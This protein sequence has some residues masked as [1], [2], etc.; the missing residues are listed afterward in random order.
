M[1]LIFYVSATSKTLI[2]AV[3]A[4]IAIS[5]LACIIGTACCARTRIQKKRLEKELRDIALLELRKALQTPP[6]SSTSVSPAVQQRKYVQDPS[7]N[8]KNSGEPAQFEYDYIVNPK[9]MSTTSVSQPVRTVQISQTGWEKN[10]EMNEKET[11]DGTDSNRT[12]PSRGWKL[13]EFNPAS[14]GK[15]KVSKDVKKTLA[16]PSSKFKHDPGKNIPIAKTRKTEQEDEVPSYENV[17]S[18]INKPK[19]VHETKNRR[20]EAEYRNEEPEYEEIVETDEKYSQKPVEY[21][22]TLK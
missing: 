6:A 8:T 9:N 3:I 2:I 17:K 16:V 19:Q 4:T 15:K 20:D 12:S 10:K 22:N 13:P 11:K 7:E 1:I 18:P 14:D 5:L 21:M